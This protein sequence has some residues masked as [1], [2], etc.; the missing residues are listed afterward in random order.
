ME[1]GTGP[2]PEASTTAMDLQIKHASLTHS[3]A[4]GIRPLRR[5][6]GSQAG[7]PLEGDLVVRVHQLGDGGVRLRLTAWGSLLEKLAELDL[8]GPHV[9]RRRICPPVGGSVSA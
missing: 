5:A 3:S 1:S 4:R 6:P 2:T 7:L 9:R 8:C